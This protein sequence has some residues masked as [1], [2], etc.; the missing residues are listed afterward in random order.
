MFADIVRHLQNFFDV[1]INE[2]PKYNS[3]QLTEA[4]KDKEG[5]LLAGAEKIDAGL[6]KSLPELRAVAVAAAGYNNID[7]DALTR[8]NIM[9]MN[10]PGVADETVADFAWGQLIAAARRI[11]EAEHFVAER[12]WKAPV[13]NR[14]FGT[15]VNGKVVGIIGMGRI[16]QAIARR[17][18]GFRMPVLYYNR[19]RL[20]AIV[21]RECK[22]GYVS[23][24]QLLASAD[25]IIL[26]LPYSKKSHHLIA[27]A[28]LKKMKSSAILLNI[29]RG[30][31]ID[32]QALAV[33][34]KEKQIAGA[35]LDVFEDEPVIFQELIGLSNVILTPH[36]AGGTEATQHALAKLA[37]DNLIAALGHGPDSFQPSAILN[38]E[39]LKNR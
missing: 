19:N 35:A 2:G 36:I 12:Q 39:V 33:A 20:D 21:E 11:V 18:I 31:L 15:E 23:K 38:P 26:A 17:A 34:L 27:A 32:E 25:F 4:L 16:G 13:G 37:A 3:E 8:A 29:A 30:G 5:V 9:A 6:L 1:E 10:A 7:V 22:A 14:F 28:E 24:D